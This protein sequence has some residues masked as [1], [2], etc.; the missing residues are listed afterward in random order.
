MHT[1]TSGPLPLSRYGDCYTC[2]CSS[3]WDMNVNPPYFL[4]IISVC[5]VSSVLTVHSV[6]N[7][8]VQDNWNLPV[9]AHLKY[10]H[11]FQCLCKYCPSCSPL[12][13]SVLLLTCQAS[14][15]QTGHP[16]VL[17][18]SDARLTWSVTGISSVPKWRNVWSL[19]ALQNKVMIKSGGATWVKGAFN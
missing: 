11:Q 17:M 14:M 3:C 18:C 2:T 1:K 19:T 10:F 9:L 5:A 7:P 13:F 15:D 8:S 6:I 16:S 12:A 4:F